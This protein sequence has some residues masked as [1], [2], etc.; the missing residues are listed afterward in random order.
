ML[1]TGHRTAYPTP[2]Q[3]PG[4]PTPHPTK[5]LDPLLQPQAQENLLCLLQSVG[6]RGGVLRSE[7]SVF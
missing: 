7:R 5:H 1:L 6:V 3:A 2:C 4:T